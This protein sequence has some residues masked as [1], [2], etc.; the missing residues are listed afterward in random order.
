MLTIA[1]LK[2]MARAR[3]KDSR[4]LFKAGRYDGAYYLCGYAVEIALKARICKTL[5]WPDFPE[6]SSEFKG[7]ASLKSHSFEDLLRFSG[8]DDLIRSARYGSYW[9][10]VSQWNPENRYKTIGSV[11]KVQAE[12]MIRSA[13]ELLKILLPR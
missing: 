8:K 1:E 11:T 5:K 2:A 9:S 3:I 12:S 13:T 4:V 10:L 6:S 7:L